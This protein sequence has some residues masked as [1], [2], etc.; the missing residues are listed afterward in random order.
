[1]ITVARDVHEPADEVSAI[2]D[3]ADSLVATWA[4]SYETAEGQ[5]STSQLR[6][7]I[8]V[9]RTPSLTVS[10][11]ADDLGA[12]VSSASRLCDRLVAAGYL[13]RD[14]SP[15]SRRQVQL[16][17]TRDGQRLL[18]EIRSQ[19]LRELRGILARMTKGDRQALLRGLRA[20][21]QAEAGRP[22]ARQ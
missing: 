15:H 8:A 6:A 22:R 9:D 13:V 1:M 12:M 7:L 10:Q 2:H 3:A 19:R 21:N 20:W 16:R 5:V 17:V 4:R 18:G 11:L 14:Q